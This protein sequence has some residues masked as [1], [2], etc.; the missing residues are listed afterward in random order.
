[1]T[2]PAIQHVIGKD[3][4]A[5]YFNGVKYKE[6]DTDFPLKL[7]HKKFLR[8]GIDLREWDFLDYESCVDSH[9]YDLEQLLSDMEEAELI[10]YEQIS[11]NSYWWRSKGQLPRVLSA[12][13]QESFNH[14][15]N[16]L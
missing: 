2:T 14:Y 5:L 12:L 16:Y 13:P 4:Q 9:Y 10:Y 3:R 8:E 1:M 7:L 15:E 6:T 11:V